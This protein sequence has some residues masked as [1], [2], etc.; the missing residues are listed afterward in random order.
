[1]PVAY[2][3]P[4]YYVSSVP[5][6]LP[7]GYQPAPAAYPVDPATGLPW[8]WHPPGLRALPHWSWEARQAGSRQ[9]RFSQASAP[10]VL[11]GRDR[12]MSQVSESPH[13]SPRESP[14][15]EAG[16]PCVGGSGGEISPV[17]KAQGKMSPVFGSSPETCNLMAF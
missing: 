14:R 3:P 6:T 17:Q 10:G 9:R 13:E 12:R 2:P 5:V 16:G 1:M 8:N 11:D 15:E 7:L 4:G